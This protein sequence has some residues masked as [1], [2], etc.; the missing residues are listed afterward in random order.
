M[1]ISFDDCYQAMETRDS[2][3]DGRVYVG[4]T[5]TGIYCRPSCASRL[6]KRENVRIYA[7]AGDA[8]E[9]G[10]RACLRCKPD[11]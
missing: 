1:K 9:A 4:V 10:F 3:F 7:T 5:S 6:P 2:G 11:A 8:R